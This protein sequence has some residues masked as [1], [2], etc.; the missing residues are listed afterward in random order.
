MRLCIP[1]TADEG[2]DSEVSQHFGS[3]PLFMMIDT[4]SGERRAV[5]NADQHHSHGAC[6]P[7][8]AMAGEA[9]DAIVVGG[10]GGGALSRLRRA[11]LR[12]YLTRLATVEAVLA[13]LAADELMEATLENAC[14]HHGH[15]HGDGCHGHGAPIKLS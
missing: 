4:E 11:G 8:K 5:A 9:V 14:G 13:A 6:Q 12:V 10:I 15:G 2:V 3:A 1:V 7:L